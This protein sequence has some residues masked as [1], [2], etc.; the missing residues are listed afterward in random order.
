MINSDWP[1]YNPLSM[2]DTLNAPLGRMCEKTYA[3][4]DIRQLL[5][6]W[7]LNIKTLNYSNKWMTRQL[8]MLLSTALFISRVLFFPSRCPAFLS[9]L[10]HSTDQ[11]LVPTTPVI[12]MRAEPTGLTPLVARIQSAW[13]SPPASFYCSTRGRLSSQSIRLKESLKQRP[14]FQSEKCEHKPKG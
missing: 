12:K 9:S 1:E 8:Y 4:S 5:A 14:S 11:V 2:Q 7:S 6:Y 3:A 13:S 10:P